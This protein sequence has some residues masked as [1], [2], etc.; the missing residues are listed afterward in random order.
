MPPGQTLNT[1][2]ATILYQ[3]HKPCSIGLKIVSDLPQFANLPYEGHF[4][5][6]ST[7]WLLKRLLEI[8]QK[9]LEYVFFQFI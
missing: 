1:K 3:S 2:S 9:Y 8:E 6:D 5:A 7:T 4:G